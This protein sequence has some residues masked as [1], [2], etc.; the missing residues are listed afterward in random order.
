MRQDA[1]VLVGTQPELARQRL[2]DLPFRHLRRRSAAARPSNSGLPS[3]AAHQRVH[4]VLRMRHQ[5]HAPAD[6]ASRPRRC[7][8]RCRCGWPPSEISPSGHRV[9][10]RHQPLALQPVQRRRHRQSSCRRHA[11]SGHGTPGSRSVTA[12]EGGVGPLHPQMAVHGQE[13]QSG[14]VQQRARQQS[15]PRSAPGSR[16]TRP[17]RSR[18]SA[19]RAP[20]SRPSPATAPPWHRS[21]DSRRS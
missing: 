7:C 16:C 14:I 18:H 6:R 8:A 1:G 4:Q 15:R 21:A 5:P 9:A 20:G 2:V 3:V 12:G 19:R 13:A 17:A 11:P 10:E